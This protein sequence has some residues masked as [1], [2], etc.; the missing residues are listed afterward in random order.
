MHHRLAAVCWVVFLHFFAAS[1]ASPLTDKTLHGLA[2]ASCALITCA[3]VSALIPAEPAEKGSFQRSLTVA[4]SGLGS[5]VLAGVVKELLDLKGF[6]RAI[7]NARV[8]QAMATVPR[9]EFVP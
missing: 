5:A 4:A 6:G 9:H 1:P 2:G 7:T 3:A 8:L